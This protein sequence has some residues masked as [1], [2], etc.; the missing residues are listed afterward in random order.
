MQYRFVQKFWNSDNID[1][2]S[3]ITDGYKSLFGCHEQKIFKMENLATAMNTLLQI[4]ININETAQIPPPTI[5]QSRARDLQEFSQREIMK[6]IRADNLQN[7]AKKFKSLLAAAYS[8]Q[9]SGL[10]IHNISKFFFKKKS[11]VV[12]EY[13]DLRGLAVLPAVIMVLDKILSP[14]ISKLVK[15]KLHSSQHGGRQQRGINTAKIELIYGAKA[16]GYNKALLIDIKRAFDTIDRPKLRAQIDNICGNDATLKIMLNTILDIYEMI[17]YDI[18]D[19]IIQ[20]K[21]GIP[22][23]SVF[24]PLFFTIYINKMLEQVKVYCKNVII[25]AYIDDIIVMSDNL[26]DLKNAFSYFKSNISSLNMNLNVKKCELLS[27]TQEEIADIQTKEIIHS[28]TAAKYLGQIINPKGEAAELIKINEIKRISTIINNT[29]S[30]L[31]RRARIKIYTIFIRSKFAHLIPLIAVSDKLE[32]TWTNIRK[33]IFS[34][35][36][37]GNTLP[38]E[39]AALMGISF[40]NII[41]KPVLK[42]LE[43]IIL[44]A[45][46]ENNDFHIS[47]MKQASKNIF[48]IWIT[49]EPNHTP[50]MKEMILEFLTN[51]KLYTTEEYSK[52]LIS[53]AAYRLF[54]NTQI[55]ENVNSLTKL[56]L[57]RLIELLSNVTL[58][59]TEQMVNSNNCNKL[60]KSEIKF[61]KEKILSYM[62]VEKLLDVPKFNL[63]KP[64]K[65]N[66]K[67]IIEYQQLLDLKIEVMVSKHITLLINKAS[68]FINEIL[69]NN[70]RLG[71]NEEI[72]WPK[73]LSDIIHK[74]R[75]SIGI[76]SKEQ[77]I[78]LEEAIEKMLFLTNKETKIN[79]TKAK[80]GRPKKIIPFN[81]NK[82]S[83]FMASFLAKYNKKNEEMD[84][85]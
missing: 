42:L 78:I 47:F 81:D 34:D 38:R 26:E 79:K 19:S 22:Q 8:S 13:T 57:P 1:K 17:N 39:A 52:A 58:H 21:R 49:V 14:L 37:L 82:S 40:F 61:V 30:M 2:K 60:H 73:S 54:R 43:N 67:D 25:E 63:P 36:L 66:V 23:G 20:P 10:I 12:E 80:P 83:E 72:V 31:S 50:R 65:E 84:E 29:T 71:E 56:N 28:K 33:N 55:P 24:G 53:E 48:K 35:A 69:N 85:D 15:N 6:I 4:V 51:D 68:D 7:T 27:E 16:K 46:N 3:K 74:V 59:A 77:W 64:D 18:C 5:P 75:H 62:I 32:D 70:K 9:N 44:R 11:D 41:V 45:N 76:K